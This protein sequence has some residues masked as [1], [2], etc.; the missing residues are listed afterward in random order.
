MRRN[1]RYM[2]FRD[3]KDRMMLTYLRKPIMVPG[4]SMG[5]AGYVKSDLFPQNIGLIIDYRHRDDTTYEYACAAMGSDSSIR[6]LMEPE[7]YLDFVRGKPYARTTVLHE[8]G[9]VF[10]NDLPEIDRDGTVY[11][12][13]R[14]RTIESGKVH[15][16]EICAD[17]FAA[18]FLGAAVVIEGLTFLREAD[19]AEDEQA[20]APSILELGRRIQI[21]DGRTNPST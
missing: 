15:E 18:R 1:I 3:G 11:D 5:L 16:R 9:H 19:I 13:E 12:A 10:H 4:R 21:L 6:I 20:N 7:V 14:L 17:A 8:L 2:R